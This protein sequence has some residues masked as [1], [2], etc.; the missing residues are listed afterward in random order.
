MFFDNRLAAHDIGPNLIFIGFATI[1]Q[2]QLEEL[3]TFVIS[4]PD[5]ISADIGISNLYFETTNIFCSVKIAPTYN[6]IT[7]II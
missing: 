2:I 7:I 1:S 5:M 4:I 3:S 6:F